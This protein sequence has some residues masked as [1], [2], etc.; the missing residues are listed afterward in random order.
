[1]G[2]PALNTHSASI[3]LISIITR[4]QLYRFTFTWA[5]LTHKRTTTTTTNVDGVHK[6]AANSQQ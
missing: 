6:K 1:M 4:K 3:K 5:A 2:R